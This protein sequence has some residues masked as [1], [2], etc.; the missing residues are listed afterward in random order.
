M[1]ISVN[2]KVRL[3]RTFKRFCGLFAQLLQKLSIRATNGPDKLLKVT[4]LFVV[5]DHSVAQFTS[6]C[7]SSLLVCFETLI[8]GFTLC[9]QIVKGP[10]TK[11]F[12]LDCKRLGFSWAA[13]RRVPM[14]EY[15][16]ELPDENTVVFVVCRVC[17]SVCL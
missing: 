9:P 5:R 2:P 7:T 11:Y 15:V 3:P 4:L 16:K 8:R 6:L 13:S 10:V 14:H 17:V 12:P 1:L